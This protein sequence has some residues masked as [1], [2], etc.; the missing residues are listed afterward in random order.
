M[1]VQ[2]CSLSASLCVKLG[3]CWSVPAAGTLGFSWQCQR[4]LQGLNE[5]EKYLLLPKVVP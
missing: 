4:S 1:S 3:C 5:S 2:S